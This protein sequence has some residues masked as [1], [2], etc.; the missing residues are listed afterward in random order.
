M[1]LCRH[2]VGKRTVIVLTYCPKRFETPIG[3]GVAVSRE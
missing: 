2:L 3:V 1:L